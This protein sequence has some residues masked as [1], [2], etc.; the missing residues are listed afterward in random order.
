MASTL[1]V[2]MQKLRSLWNYFS[3][4][5]QFNLKI[6]HI[7]RSPNLLNSNFRYQ[8]DECRSDGARN[9]WNWGS[10]HMIIYYWFNQF[11]ILLTYVHG[12][13]L[14]TKYYKSITVEGNFYFIHVFI[15]SQW[16]CKNLYIIHLNVTIEQVM[17]TQF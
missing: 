17:T 14:S 16:F 3:T 8:N 11:F 4:K 15:T 13:Y 10:F 7:Y 12:I 2:S 5:Y 1:Y 9:T 6:L